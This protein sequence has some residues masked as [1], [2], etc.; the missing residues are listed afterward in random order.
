[1]TSPH[2]GAAAKDPRQGQRTHTLEERGQWTWAA[3]ETAVEGI[4]T[5]GEDGIIEYVNPAMESLFGYRREELLG[6]SVNMLMPSPYREEHDG[7]LERYLRTGERHIIGIGREVVGQRKD[8]SIFP[9]H[10]AVSEVKLEDRRLFTGFLYD[11]S[12]RKAHEERQNHLLQELNKRN[13][14]I[15]CLYRVGETLR[16]TEPSDEVFG[17][18]AQILHTALAHP[19]LTGTRIFV[20]DTAHT[21]EDYQETPWVV[22]SDIVAGGR[23][24][25]AVEAFFVQE[26]MLTR[27][28]LQSERALINAVAEVLSENIERSEAE[29]KVIHASKLASVGEL[30]AGVG[31]EINNPV[32]G[33]INCADIILKEA[34]RESTTY[35]FAELIRSEA[36]RIATIVHNLLTF[37]R[38]EKQQ[39]SR[40]D[41]HDIVDTVISLCGKKL[42]RSNVHLEIDLPKNL[43]LL[44]CRSEQLQQVIMNLVINSMHALD[45]KYPGDDP[46]KKLVIRA[47]A[48]DVDGREFIRVTVEDHGTGISE[49]HR[50][51][52][53]DPFFTTKG[54]DRGTGLGLSISDGIVKGHGGTIECESQVG[55]YTRFIIELPVKP[56]G[57]TVTE[58]SISGL[59]RAGATGGPQGGANPHR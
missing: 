18:A 30:A 48:Y 37:S 43:P 35:K 21:S 47:E 36:D 7:Y 2:D 34:E 26:D 29:A 52:M 17:R 13:R 31:H 3:V 55:A 38:Q 19:A 8:G 5:I 54:R 9:M 22:S 50:Q 6:Q 4:A 40:A 16:A 53:F 32:N 59:R 51:R 28:E 45:E 11:I 1:M 12:E 14:E 57:E 56:D 39:H 41:L 44:Y 33:I 27:D 20:D 15:N 58:Q 24:R 25:G 42:Q 10:L 49:N 46:D 23:K